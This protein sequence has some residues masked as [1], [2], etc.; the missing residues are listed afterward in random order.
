VAMLYREL[1]RDGAATLPPEPEAGDRHVYHHFVI[2]VARRDAFRAL[3]QEE[4]IGTAV[5]YPVALHR[6]RALAA[7]GHRPGDFPV[8][9]RLEREIVSLPMFPHLSH[10]QVERVAQAVLRHAAPPE[11]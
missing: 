1:L 11:R 4:G 7:L 6:Q 9:E 5:H 3:L 2:R 8:A 10:E